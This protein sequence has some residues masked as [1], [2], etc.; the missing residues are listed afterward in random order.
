MKILTLISGGDVGGA[1]T[2]VLGLLRALGEHIAVKLVC[3]MEAEFTDA[4]REMGI[5]ITILDS[6]DLRA[7]LGEL[8]G[9]IAREGFDLIH[10]HGSRGNFMAMLLKKSSGLPL[11][12]TVHSDWKLDYMGRPLA[13]LTF[14]R[15][16]LLALR[17]MDYLVGVSDSMSE[18]LIR[19]RMA[20]PDRVYTIYNGVD[21]SRP[22]SAV[23]RAE[24]FAA[25]GVPDEPETVYMGIAARLNPVKDMETLVRGF[26]A[27]RK[28]Q[29]NI[30]LLIAG[31]GPEEERLKAL[32]LS[33]GVQDRVHFLGWVT[34]TDS[35]YNA[36]DVN[37]LTSLSETFP[38]A[39]TEGAVW[40][41]ATVSSRVG[42]VP[43]LID[44]GVSGLLFTPGDW[45]TLGRELAELAGSPD[46]RARCA[47]KLQEK[48]RREFSLEATVET[49]LTIYRSVLRR[50]NRQEGKQSA[51]TVCGA[52]GRGNVGDEAILQ[53]ILGEIREADPDVTIYAV[54]R[55][56]RSTR[57]T[58][59]VRAVHTFDL[60]AFW[61]LAGRTKLL[62]NGGGSLI[63][64][65]T[66]RRSLWFY[67]Y[68]LAA[69]KR[70]GAKVV[71]Y[72]C[73]IG[74][75]K[76]PGDQRLSRR[77]ISK[78][79]DVITLREDHSRE[80]LR[81][82]GVEGPEILL[83]A[84]PS[85]TLDGAGEDRTE[86]ALL[87]AG[88]DPGG[89]Y[90]C[91]ALRPWPGFEEKAPAFARAAETLFTETGLTP[92][93]LP[94]DQ[95]RD[96]AAMELVAKQLRAP[97]GIL[98][99]APDPETVMGILSRMKAVVSMRLHGLIFAAGQGVPLV[100]VVY[101]P[102]VRA[103]LRYIG[104]D[105]TVDL[106]DVTAEGLCALVSSALESSG[107]EEQARA[108]ARLRDLDR[109]NREV[110]RRYLSPTG[111]NKIGSEK[112]S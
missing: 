22:R 74:P 111:Q 5:D 106:G 104:Q 67:L 40:G 6:R 24:F 93:F 12:S 29:P 110:L 31:D 94:I 62:L 10:S 99:A 69:A 108:V 97:H 38:Y 56:P 41:K 23:S 36:L 2:H 105:R 3:F 34:D 85:L 13:A 79:A 15:L 63:Q 95:S 35:F 76:F 47:A 83:A 59:R 100:G 27:A 49:Q 78:N 37:T 98:P 80:E 58:H 54:S 18:L 33:L 39:L 64:D 96:P 109:V 50:H 72:G 48:T 30:R 14:G 61:R 92:V 65:V 90:L 8:R 68:T 73:G 7:V 71:M 55:D 51:V 28:T 103:F 82:M 91:F 11:V 21:F 89:N 9:M 101:D 25:H 19:R 77:I 60:L 26:A 17:R 4:A 107:G 75:V 87:S 70:R 81:R 1:K 53:A 43:R 46:L 57:V 102:K 32:A 44:H 86:S 112:R 20:Q 45:E 42:G 52:Y 84:D 88:L 16:N 66:S